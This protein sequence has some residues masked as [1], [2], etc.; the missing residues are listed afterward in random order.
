LISSCGRSKFG[1]IDINFLL[2]MFPQG[3]Y[4]PGGFTL[5]ARDFRSFG[6]G[7]PGRLF[8]EQAEPQNGGKTRGV[9]RSPRLVNGL[10]LLPGSTPESVDPCR[11]GARAEALGFDQPCGSIVRK[12]GMPGI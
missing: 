12:P 10:L 5:R 2:T 8:A 7:Q 3:Q 11:N 1:G 9:H 6:I 4:A